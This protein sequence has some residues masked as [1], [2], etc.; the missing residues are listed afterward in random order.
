MCSCRKLLD[1]FLNS[2]LISWHLIQNIS[3]CSY[4]LTYQASHVDTLARRKIDFPKVTLEMQ[5]TS[6][7]NWIFDIY[8]KPCHLRKQWRNFFILGL[9]WTKTSLTFSKFI[10]VWSKTRLEEKLALCVGNDLSLGMTSWKMMD[11]WCLWVGMAS[12]LLKRPPL[13][14]L[15]I[16]V[17]DS[18]T[19]PSSV[20]EEIRA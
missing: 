20:G 13:C 8:P 14:L 4:C 16:D 18:I 7:N 17:S 12:H 2:Q 15:Y 19:N 10:S 3:L 11:T 6:C 1:V 9:W 5:K